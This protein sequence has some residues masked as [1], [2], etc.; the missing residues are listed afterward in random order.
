MHQRASGAGAKGPL[1]QGG[2]ENTTYIPTARFSHTSPNTFRSISASTQAKVMAQPGGGFPRNE[3]D[4]R[5]FLRDIAG[6][7]NPHSPIPRSTAQVYSGPRATREHAGV[8][9]RGGRSP[10]G[11]FH[12]LDPVASS[13]ND[14]GVARASVQAIDSGFDEAVAM[15]ASPNLLDLGARS[16]V[17]SATQEDTRA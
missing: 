10:Q 5:G 16:A 17:S 11:A 14:A 7:S 9:T 3:V 12:S 1:A 2:D 13:F 6:V 4:K 8:A 15:N